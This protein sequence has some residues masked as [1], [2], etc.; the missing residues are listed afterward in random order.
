[1]LTD[2]AKDRETLLD[3]DAYGTTLL[4][5]ALDRWGA[6]ATQWRPDVLRRNVE[7]AGRVQLPDRNFDR[8]MAAVAVLTTD[9]FFQKADA[10]ASLTNALCGDG[11]QPA[12]FD[13]PEAVECAWAITE[14]LLLDPFD[15]DDPDDEHRFSPEVRRYLGELLRRE[16]F[17]RAP[18]VLGL[19][20]GLPP[21]PRF[22]D[23]PELAAAV[24]AAQQA[25][26][27]EV[28]DAVRGGLRDLLT[29]LE[30]LR[31]HGHGDVKDLTQRLQQT[32]LRERD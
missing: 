26:E 8:L 17:V 20:T 6:E 11:F 24:A 9:L 1:M 18:D 28:E 16:G 25:R 23:D 2:A 4:V 32:K 13:P 30:G 7:E 3:P 29:Q 15:D 27:R 14:A 22:D 31:L 5:W 21:A 10:F 19:A 12:E